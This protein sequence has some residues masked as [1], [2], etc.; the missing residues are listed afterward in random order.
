MG[1]NLQRKDFNSIEHAITNPKMFPA[2]IL[3]DK[4]QLSKDTGKDVI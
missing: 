1:D 3:Y 2:M 4:H